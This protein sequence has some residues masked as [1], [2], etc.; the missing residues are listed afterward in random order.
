METVTRTTTQLDNMI[1]ICLPCYAGHTKW[2]YFGTIFV[3]FHERICYRHLSDNDN[4]LVY[5]VSFKA[6]RS[7]EDNGRMIMKGSVQ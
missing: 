5:Y 2:K 3:F 7:Y 4:N 1:P 6:F